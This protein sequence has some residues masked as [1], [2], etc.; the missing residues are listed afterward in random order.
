MINET[1]DAKY[2]AQLFSV[3]L[4]D[5]IH[6]QIL[7]AEVLQK[8]VLQLCVINHLLPKQLKSKTCCN[9]ILCVFHNVHHVI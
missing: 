1:L 3:S 7:I 5:V 8:Q 4:I 2:L 9:I 6:I